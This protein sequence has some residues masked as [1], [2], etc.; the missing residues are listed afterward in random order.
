MSVFVDTNVAFAQRH[1]HA[2]RHETA[3]RALDGIRSGRYGQPM[4]SDYVVDETFTLA[5]HRTGRYELARSTADWLLGEA[6]D[7]RQVF[8][9][10]HVEPATFRSALD[11]LDSYQDHG[12][13]FT[14][15]T[16][17]ALIDQHDVDHLLS[18]DTGFDGIVDRLD[19]AKVAD[20]S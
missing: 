15:A 14:D 7:H 12:L 3:T 1:D 9:L 4:T 10:L 6:A 11:V 16:T 13:S 8:D 20:G 19:P 5:L 2:R 17:V 18:F